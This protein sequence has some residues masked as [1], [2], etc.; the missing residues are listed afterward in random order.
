MFDLLPVEQRTAS[1]AALSLSSGFGLI[2]LSALAFAVRDWRYIL[3][4]ASAVCFVGLAYQWTVPESLQWLMSRNRILPAQQVFYKILANNRQF[5][6]AGV[7]VAITN[8]ARSMTKAEQSE[9]SWTV[10]LRSPASFRSFLAIIG[11]W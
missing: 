10:L 4:A 5:V 9:Q 6:P 11:L 7:E 1:A 2:F 3:I 8:A